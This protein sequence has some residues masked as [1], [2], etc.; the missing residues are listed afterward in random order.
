MRKI[1]VLFLHIICQVSLAG[2]LFVGFSAHAQVNRGELENLGP[3]EFI[4]YEGPYSRIE[5]RA[6]IR[7]I[8]YSQ[9]LMVK[10]GVNRT[11]TSGRYFVI[12][13][14]SAAADSKQDADIFGL[15]VD[16]GVDHVRNLRLI[17]QGYLEGAYGYSERDAAL[18]AE[19]VTIYNAVYRG[20]WDYFGS[21]YKAPI[22][23][24]LTKEKT[25]LSIR[26]DEWPGRTLMLIPLGLG[27]AGPLNA[28]DSGSIS[29]SRV[30]EQ[31][32]QEPDR[33]VDTRKDMVELKERQS[34]EADQQAAV[35]REAIREEE[36][37]IAREREEA[38][39]QREQARKEQDQ[40]A[41]ERQEPG[42][43]QEQLDQR[44]EAA[45]QQEQEADAKDQQLDQREETLETRREEAE[46]TQEFADQ[47][48]EEARQDREEI[49]KDQQA[50]INQENIEQTPVAGILG[51]SILSPDGSLGRVVKLNPDTGAE[52]KRSLLNTINVRTLTLAG[53]KIIAI[54]GEDRGSGAVR[55]IELNGDSLEM[56][57]QGEDDI[58]PQSL[59]WTDGSGL[60]AIASSG[61]KLYLARF[62]TDLVLEA[63][64]PVAVHPYGGVTFSGGYIITQRSDGSAVLLN[65][66][67]LS[68]KR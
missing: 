41:R 62:N 19:Y 13:S 23:E 20:D 27:S 65:S 55:L 5:T 44:E 68:E 43:N 48:A 47:K 29:D 59:L 38:A 64:S 60:Y 42:A 26:Y 10:N 24:N 53:G 21:R 1:G 36:E 30:T 46:Q 3:V 31:L 9:G 58:S 18:L 35:Q 54:A 63:R 15:G 67:D 17:I 33:G 37:K 56:A 57:K 6:Q 45:R 40:I 49:A 61:G 7:A 66:G 32:R 16:V 14:V 52:V 28:V 11:G 12:H 4:N 2:L 25:G 34:E 22:M 8:G 51:A 39:Q 50:M